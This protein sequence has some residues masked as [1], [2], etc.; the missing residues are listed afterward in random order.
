MRISLFTLAVG[1][2]VRPKN[3]VGKLAGKTN[4]PQRIDRNANGSVPSHH[5]WFLLKSGYT[6]R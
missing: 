5:Q 4:K 1:G 2:A 6:T 3:R